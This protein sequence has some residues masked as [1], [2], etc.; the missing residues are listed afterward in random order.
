MVGNLTKE[1]RCMLDERGVEHQDRYCCTSWIGDGTLHMAS[2]ELDGMLVVNKLTPE[3]AIIATLG[4]DAKP[5]YAT[6]YTHG[7]CKYSVNRGWTEDTKFYIPTLRHGTLGN[8]KVTENSIDK[9]LR[10]FQFAHGELAHIG[11]NELKDLAFAL[12]NDIP[13]GYEASMRLADWLLHAILDDEKLTAEQVHKAIYKYGVNDGSVYS[14]FKGS[15]QAI[16]DELNTTLGNGECEDISTTH[17][18]FKCSNCLCTVKEDGVDYGGINYCPDCG[19][20]V[21]R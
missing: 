12:H 15:F 9:W 17:G 13:L 18:I 2:E 8:N 10:E 19:K 20:V 11:P 16:A 6:D 5:C 7:H 3:Q 4:S 1:L 21:K 14:V